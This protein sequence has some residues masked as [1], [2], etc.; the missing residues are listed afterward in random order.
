MT[1]SVEQDLIDALEVVS[2]KAD[3]IQDWVSTLPRMKRQKFNHMI[4]GIELVARHAIAKA[5]DAN[6]RQVK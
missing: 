2:E 1:T 6:E 5:E 4:L 3:K